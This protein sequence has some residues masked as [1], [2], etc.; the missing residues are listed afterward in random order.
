MKKTITFIALSVLGCSKPTIIVKTN[1]A[2]ALV[3]EINGRIQKTSP[4]TVSYDLKQTDLKSDGCYRINGF[5]ATWPSGATS[6]TSEI[7]RMCLENGREFA[8][9]INRP[10]SYPGLEIDMANAYQAQKLQIQQEQYRQQQIDRFNDSAANLGYG[11]G[12]TL[13]K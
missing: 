7:L 1:P 5:R 12:L 13:R 2:G 6:Q 3:T 8:I 11:I 4:V 9:E 10:A